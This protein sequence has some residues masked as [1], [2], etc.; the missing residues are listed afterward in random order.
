MC[1]CSCTSHH[2]VSQWLPRTG[3]PPIS[4][5]IFFS[6]TLLKRN[7]VLPAA[8]LMGS[9]LPCHHLPVSHWLS[10][11]FS[12]LWDMSVLRGQVL[13]FPLPLYLF[14]S[15]KIPSQSIPWVWYP[16]EQNRKIS[17]TC[18]FITVGCSISESNHYILIPL[19]VLQ[20]FFPYS[21][22]GV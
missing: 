13:Q 17:E 2:S 9:Y 10:L 12:E 21:R 8:L 14:I 3:V 18:I 16:M 1:I 5:G 22:I 20:D 11:Y 15:S 19:T 4:V 6:E 7:Y